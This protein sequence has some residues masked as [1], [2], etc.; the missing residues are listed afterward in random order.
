MAMVRGG[1]AWAF[2]RYSHD[3]VQQELEARAT[4]LGVHFRGR[5][6]AWEW[7]AHQRPNGCP[8]DPKVWGWMWGWNR[9]HTENID[10]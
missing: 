8:S 4:G 3:Y 7:T 9:P 5:E 1:M 10:K 6:P 2:V